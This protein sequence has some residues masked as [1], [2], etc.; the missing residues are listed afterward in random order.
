M[1]S[2]HADLA[3]ST[4]LSANAFKLGLHAGRTTGVTPLSRNSRRKALV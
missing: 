3:D 4:N 1:R 2:K